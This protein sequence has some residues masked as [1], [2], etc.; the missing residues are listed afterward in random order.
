[1]VVALWIVACPAISRAEEGSSQSWSSTAPQGLP[2]ADAFSAQSSVLR[3]VG[4]LFLCFGVLGF[5]IHV[6]KRHVLPRTLSS[7]RRLQV[8]ERIPLSQKS[9]L[10]L[11][12]LDGKEFLMSTG[13]ESS[14]LVPLSQ[15]QED[16]FDET[17]ANACNDVG[18]YNV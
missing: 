14:R 6:Y 8:I 18:E 12:K 15:R 2:H 5:G 13:A 11:V 10:V 9:A 3:M 7:A 17:L 16:L 1:M 4:G